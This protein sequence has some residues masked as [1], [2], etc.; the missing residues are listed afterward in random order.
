MWERRPLCSSRLDSEIRILRPLITI[1][2]GDDVVEIAAARWS[3][4]H[5]YFD[6]KSSS[7]SR[8]LALLR[9]QLLRENRRSA[10][11]FSHPL[12]SRLSVAD[13]WPDS[14][15]DEDMDQEMARSICLAFGLV[16]HDA[17]S[18]R[19]A[20]TSESKDDSIVLT[21]KLRWHSAEQPMAANSE[22]S[23]TP[24]S[25]KRMRR[26]KFLKAAGQWRGLSVAEL[27]RSSG[28]PGKSP[29]VYA[30]SATNFP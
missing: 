11:P 10:G 22:T 27:A 19:P 3:V 4:E 26:P 12:V 1:Q 18:K 25:G 14:Q 29:E 7:R 16:P 30:T 2:L 28:F 23:P 9:E 8:P 5:D 17:D 24:L 21:H 20:A 13:R 15:P 6:T